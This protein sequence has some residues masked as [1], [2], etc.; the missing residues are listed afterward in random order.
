MTLGIAIDR[1]C[2]GVVRSG[3]GEHAA[4]TVAFLRPGAI[5][6]QNHAKPRYTSAPLPNE[7]PYEKHALQN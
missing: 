6:L 3:S 5:S 2:F 1:Q 7:S 4:S